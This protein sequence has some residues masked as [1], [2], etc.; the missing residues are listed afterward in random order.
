MYLIGSWYPGNIQDGNSLHPTMQFNR[1][2]PRGIPIGDS[3]SGGRGTIAICRHNSDTNPS[4]PP[5]SLIRTH[6]VSIFDRSNR[7]LFCICFAFSRPKPFLSP[8]FN[9]G[10]LFIL[11]CVDKSNLAVEIRHLAHGY[12]HLVICLREHYLRITGH[13]ET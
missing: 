3:R 9:E 11:S 6:P 1:M 5:V 13:P 2:R 7:T 10:C 8:F 4:V 12:I